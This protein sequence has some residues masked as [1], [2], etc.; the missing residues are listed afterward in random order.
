MK[1]E[2][3]LIPDDEIDETADIVDISVTEDTST[4]RDPRVLEN[5]KRAARRRSYMRNRSKYVDR[6]HRD[7]SQQSS[8]QTSE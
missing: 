6:R 3:L 5:E 8:Q 7:Q 1:L 2:D 4:I